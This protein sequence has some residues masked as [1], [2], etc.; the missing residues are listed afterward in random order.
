M[1]SPSTDSR[2]LQRFQTLLDLV[3][4]RG[5]PGC[6]QPLGQDASW[7]ETCTAALLAATSTPYCPRCGAA[8]EPYL[9]DSAGCRRCRRQSSPLDGLA[10]VGPYP[11]L[12]GEMV[13]RYKY[14]RQQR[15]DRP[16]GLLLAH[17]IAGRSW[18]GSIDALVPIPASLRERLSYRFSPV[19]LLASTVGKQLSLPVLPLIVVR[20]KR[21]QQV[22]LPAS[23]RAANVR[24]IFHVARHA[25]VRGARL[26]LVDDVATSNATLIAAA[27]ALKRAGAAE[28]YAAVLAKAALHNA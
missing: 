17:A 23:E 2:I 3:F 11:T 6:D 5:C 24:G 26:C 13:R 15:L 16:L 19:A 9:L 20:G 10:R 27:R 14:Q 18:A 25:R 22:G 8:A 28:V 7:C 12:I 1:P 4:P 21:R